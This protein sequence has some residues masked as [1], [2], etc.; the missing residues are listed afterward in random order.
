MPTYNIPI[1]V[2]IRVAGLIKDAADRAQSNAPLPLSGR[3]WFIEEVRQLGVAIA[4][5]EFELQERASRI[6]D[7]NSIDAEVTTTTLS[8]TAR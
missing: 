7:R 6:A 2:S 5:Q 4:R 1:T 8:R 3:D